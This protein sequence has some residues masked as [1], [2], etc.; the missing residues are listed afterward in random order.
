MNE[1]LSSERQGG[2]HVIRVAHVAGFSDTSASGVDHMVFGLVSHL[3]PDGVRA[4]VWDLNPSH[5][6]VTER[7]V[8][9]VSVFQLPSRTRVRGSLLGLPEATRRFIRGRRDGIDL[10]HLHSVFIPENVW[11]ARFARLPY[12][13]TPHGGYSPRVLAGNN[14]IAKF[15]WMRM[16]ERDYV[17]N[18]SMIHAVSPQELEELRATFGACPFVFVPNAIDLPAVGTSPADRLLG[19]SKRIVFLGRL[20]IDHKGLDILLEGY[21]NY[22]RQ[23]GDTDTELIVAGPDFRSGRD[24]LEALAASLLPS[25]HVRFTGPLFGRD[26]EALLGSA[27]VFVHTS[28]WEG[29]PFA[30]LEALAT[31]C[32]VL[33]TPATNLGD[34]VEEFGAGVVVDG[35]A[36][37]VS[38]GL[39]KILETPTER[40]EAHCAAARRLASARF[41]WPNVAGQMIAEYRKILG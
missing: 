19:P 36:Q 21:A 31:G 25:G 14:R 28:R 13:L 38:E 40:Y 2:G 5:A 26:R 3:D 37:S 11:V 39:R 35:S 34:Y 1:P 27:Y 16:W 15:V 18:A 4:E 6:S 12:V 23:Q 9:S 22:V 17:R 41:T 20:A 8:G 10:L 30:I 33:V 7:R 29:M 24:E 32:P